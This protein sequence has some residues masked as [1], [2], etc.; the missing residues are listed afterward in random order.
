MIGIGIPTSHS[1][2]PRIGS[3]LRQIAY[4]RSRAVS[5]SARS[6]APGNRWAVIVGAAG[7]S[8]MQ[9]IGAADDRPRCRSGRGIRCRRGVR[10][11]RR[12]VGSGAAD[13]T[14]AANVSRNALRAVRLHALK[15]C[16]HAVLLAI[17]VG[18]RVGLRDVIAVDLIGNAGRCGGDSL[19]RF[20][21]VG[22][23]GNQ[24]GGGEKR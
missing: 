7:Q 19:R 16:V 8:L 9:G 3:L 5:P 20:R 13:P 14:A 24:A 23:A 1:N 18:L 11:R 6:G 2:T 10:R 15:I 12:A 22:A 21:R 17:P 4:A